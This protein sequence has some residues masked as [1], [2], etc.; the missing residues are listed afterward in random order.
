MTILLH[1]ATLVTMDE[2]R[3]VLK[4]QK[5]LI[6]GGEITGFGEHVKT[7]GLAI[8]ERIDCFG[9]IVIPGLVNTHSHLL[10]ILQRSFRDNV[11]KEIWLWHRQMTEDAAQLS[12][13]DIGAAAALACAE[14]LKN[15]VTAVLDH[16]PLRSEITAAKMNA[17]LMAFERTGIRGI[18]AP[19]LRDQDFMELLGL[20]LSSRK[21]PR[22]A[23]KGG[24][25]DFFR[26]EMMPV[27][28][29]V[30]KSST[31]SNLML[32]P[33]SPQTCSDSLLRKVVRMAEQYDLGIHT[34]LL[35]SVIE[36]W[37]GRRLYRGGMVQRIKMLGLLSP[38]LSAAHCVWLN[39]REM[40]LM[41][42]SG[43][44]VIH[45][46]AS[47]LKLGSGI[48]PVVELK[49]RGVNVALGTD[50]GDTSDSYSIFQQ[51]RLAAFLSRLTTE[52]SDHWVTALDALRM[53][54]INGAEA[55]PAWRGKIGKIKRGYRADLVILNPNIRLYPLNDVI[56]QLVY[57]EG[58]QS[59]DTV[60]VDGKVVVRNGLLTS[61]E[62]TALIQKVEPISEKMYRI[63]NL[64]KK[65][66][67]KTELAIRRLYRKAL[68]NSRGHRGS[69]K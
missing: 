64:N 16:F 23:P 35:E 19:A 22:K 36:R 59:V 39:E 13:D 17:I 15:G 41:A 55:I 51:M 62:E 6:Q 61:V 63:Y 12:A 54:T 2:R 32:G 31:I 38:R 7:D 46:P 40:D 28:E 14:M 43:A 52:N 9:K 44:S 30:R 3:P 67:G 68:G 10:E 69:D 53:G 5:L 20:G 56:H 29:H 58:G 34:H 60:L 45:N 57:C 42:S 8:D 4:K 37:G 26:D 49:R 33:S 25:G 65:R 66:A 18:L 24:A 27:L 11:R 48:A 21:A 50:G 47:N 1:D